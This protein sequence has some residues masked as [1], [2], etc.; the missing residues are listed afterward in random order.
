MNSLLALLHPQKGTLMQGTPAALSRYVPCWPDSHKECIQY[1]FGYVLSLYHT[2]EHAIHYLCR[3]TDLHKKETFT[4]Y[5]HQAKVLLHVRVQGHAQVVVNEQLITSTVENT[6][7]IVYLPEGEITSDIESGLGMSVLADITTV[8]QRYA[9]NSYPIQELL[10]HI[11]EKPADA[12]LLPA[13][14]INFWLQ[15]IVNVILNHGKDPLHQPSLYK[16]IDQLIRLYLL[17]MDDHLPEL[18]RPR[19]YFEVLSGRK[20]GYPA[21]IHNTI[22]GKAYKKIE[23]Y[24]L[25]NIHTQ[26]LKEDAALAMNMGEKEFSNLFKDGY[27]KPYR[28]GYL[29]LRMLKAYEL[30]LQG[31]EKLYS[32]ARN[33][34]YTQQSAFG[35]RF[36]EFF[37]YPA[38]LFKWPY[39]KTK[40]TL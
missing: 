25:E 23:H 3:A 7:R 36:I 24:L 13:M 18:L 9:A 14:F 4:T 39:V 27:G 19:L 15:G 38:T 12:L 5:Q 11:E 40:K 33:V 8:I 22:E 34:G 29:E 31:D 17:H 35:E 1:S 6:V 28:E 30:V 2:D 10:R 21:L 26:L 32:V 20:A 16:I 37:G